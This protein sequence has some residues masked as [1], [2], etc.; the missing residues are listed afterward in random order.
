MKRINIIIC[1]IL[2]M[3]QA[4]NAN[5][6][7]LNRGS[8]YLFV[9][10]VSP[11]FSLTNPYFFNDLILEDHHANNAIF[12]PSYY[13]GMRAGVSFFSSSVRNTVF[14]VYTEFNR[15]EINQE[16]SLFNNP[17]G[18]DSYYTKN[19]KIR[20]SDISLMGRFTFFKGKSY[21]DIGRFVEIGIRQ[22]RL[23]GFTERNSILDS[24][25]KTSALGY[26]LSAHYTNKN[27]QYVLGFGQ[28]FDFL[29]WSL[30]GCFQPNNMMQEGLYAIS[31]GYYNN[32]NLN[33]DFAK[34]Y[35]DYSKTMLLSIE[36]QIEINLYFIEF[37]T[38]SCGRFTGKIAPLYLN[39]G[40]VW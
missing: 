30:R 33:P 8:R 14:C 29:A 35:S 40:Y 27:L 7:L 18:D 5:K 12:N 24:E 10:D 21:N 19:I 32:T 31:D 1:L 13:Y 16:F 39:T 17:A 23:I 26:D 6:P 15:G 36:L 2:F 34:A 20:N 22:S 9:A 37:G 11:R 4:G 25:L 28:Q 3:Y 38:A